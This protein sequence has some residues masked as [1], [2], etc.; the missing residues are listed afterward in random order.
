MDPVTHALASWSLAR[1]G[2]DRATPRAT[3]MMI[4]AG[5]APELD[6]ITLFTADAAAYLRYGG[7]V[8]HALAG[9]GLA[10]ALVAVA[11]WWF[12]RAHPQRP[13]RLGGALIVCLAAVAAHLLLDMLTPYGARLLWPAQD[14]WYA[15]DLT[16]LADVHIIG[17]LL[18]GLVLPLL[19]R[20]VTEEIGARAERRGPQRWAIAALVVVLVYCGGRWYMHQQALA[21]LDT[22]IYHGAAAVRIAAYPAAMSPWRWRAIVETENTYEELDVRIGRYFDPERSRAHYKPEASPALDAA[23]STETMRLFFRWARFPVASIQQLP[24]GRGTRIEMRD[25]RFEERGTGRR[26]ARSILAV[27]ELD[28]QLRIIHEELR[29]AGQ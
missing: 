14:R 26:P 15:A 13:V 22:R 11:F 20:L 6:L 8:T 23:R 1:A 27:V 18:A 2:L 12:G 3:A 4:A 19:F 9:A 28:P 10:G 16:F 21:M 25:L 29:W 17:I 24:E 7:A 5:L